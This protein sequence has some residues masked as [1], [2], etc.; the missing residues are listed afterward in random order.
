MAFG[1]DDDVN[2]DDGDDGN[3][4][5][6]DAG[7]ASASTTLPIR[8]APMAK[9]SASMLP[10]TS[11]PDTSTT[12]ECSGGAATC[13]CV[14]G[15]RCYGSGSCICGSE[16]GCKAPSTTSPSPSKREGHTS[17]A[18]NHSEP[19]VSPKAAPT[20]KAAP[21]PKTPPPTPKDAAKDIAKDSGAGERDKKLDGLWYTEIALPPVLEHAQGNLVK[22]AK[23]GDINWTSATGT[24]L[25]VFNTA[26]GPVTVT[27]L[28][29][30]PEPDANADDDR[31]YMLMSAPGSLEIV[32]RAGAVHLFSWKS[33][34]PDAKMYL[35]GSPDSTA[36][37]AMFVIRNPAK[38]LTYYLKGRIPGETKTEMLAPGFKLVDGTRP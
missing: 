5:G 16:C 15:G 13:T 25:V 30:P 20:P 27:S 14:G 8:A 7:S 17:D 19:S 24:A 9:P 2:A 12:C 34:D 6:S 35:Y 37:S 21:A 11:S 26:K 28:G 38:K 1:D 18:H 31:A 22:D 33:G 10:L 23:L 36:K 3:D 32:K 29:W 4:G